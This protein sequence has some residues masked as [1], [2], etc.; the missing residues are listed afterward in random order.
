MVFTVLI[1]MFKFTTWFNLSRSCHILWSLVFLSSRS[2]EKILSI[3]FWILFLSELSN[4]A[5]LM[6]P[7][8][9]L[10]CFLGSFWIIGLHLFSILW[11]FFVLIVFLVMLIIILSWLL[12]YFRVFRIFILDLRECLTTISHWPRPTSRLFLV[13]SSS[14][15][16]SVLWRVIFGDS[17]F[18]FLAEAT[19]IF[20]HLFIALV[21]IG[22]E[23]LIITL[24]LFFME[25]LR[26]IML[27]S[28]YIP[29]SFLDAVQ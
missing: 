14:K 3:L 15:Q 27:P 26:S 25:T 10:S 16:S 2:L 18:L 9:Y 17:H 19:L 4:T 28:E 22:S 7:L 8:G 11:N 21:L 23:F 1:S 24:D 20:L 6:S 13:L 5:L 29:T 12:K